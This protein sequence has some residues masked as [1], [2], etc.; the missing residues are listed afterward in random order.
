MSLTL[1]LLHSTIRADEKLLLKAA[2][3]RRI[4]V[5]LVDI[6]RQ[7]FD[8]SYQADF[9][10]ALERSVSTSQGFYAA[11]FLESL[12]ISV[13]NS[14]DVARVCQDKFLT[15]LT[16]WQ[17]Q[18]PTPRFALVFSLDQALEFIES[19]GGFPVVI[20]PTVGSWGRLMAKINDRQALEAII[21]HKQFLGSVY[22]KSLYFQEY[23]DKPQR[24]IRAFVIDHKVIA[25]IYRRS[26]HWITNTARG[27]QA[28]NC[29]IDKDLATICQ[30]ASRAVGGGILAMDV[31]ETSNG[32]LINEINHTMEFK[33]SQ[34]PTGVN[35]SGAIIDY[36]LSFY[37]QN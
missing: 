7:R 13:I 23:I 24:D 17:A 32:Y 26:S 4:E 20:K 3:D 35:I 21:E 15:S 31:F 10:I 33:N 30:K 27:G 5:R 12:K 22:Q 8:L 34:E 6:R 16:L 36:C 2:K 11:S 29:P 14:T 28:S 18:V 25:A 9:D 37:D 1:G 19:I